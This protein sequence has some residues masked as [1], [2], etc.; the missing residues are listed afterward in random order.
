MI[1]Y[2]VKEKEGDQ[3]KEETNEDLFCKSL[4]ADLKELPPY[5]RC[6]AKNEMR[7]ILFY[8]STKCLL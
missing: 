6:M 2:R 7:N 3:N 4:A 5:E 8:L 1:A